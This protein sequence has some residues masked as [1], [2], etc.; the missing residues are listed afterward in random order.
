MYSTLGSSTTAARMPVERSRRKKMSK[1]SIRVV[2][3]AIVIGIVMSALGFGLNRW[4]LYGSWQLLLRVRDPD[5]ESVLSVRERKILF[6]A[7][8]GRMFYYVEMEPS[9]RLRRLE[10]VS[11]LNVG[12]NTTLPGEVVGDEWRSGR[13]YIGWLKGFDDVEARRPKWVEWQGGQITLRADNGV[14]ARIARE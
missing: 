3:I 13:M 7:I 2:R 14:V 11:T 12:P 5:G 6:E 10:S 1:R 8:D 4:R 9:R